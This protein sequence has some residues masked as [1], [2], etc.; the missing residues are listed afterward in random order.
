MFFFFFKFDPHIAI[1]GDIKNS[2]KIV[3]R[4]EVQTKLNH[5]LQEINQIY[6]GSIASN[7]TITLGDEFQGL[8]CSG[9]NTM[10][11]LQY[12]KKEMAPINIRFGIG[13]GHITTHVDPK[14]S[15]GADGPGYYM[16]RDSIETVKNYENRKE[17]ALCDMLI[18]IDGDNQLQEISLNST[19]KL[20]YS[21]E[22]R[23]TNKQKEI[24]NY[25][26]F[27]DMSQTEVSQHFNV[28]PSNIQQIL[29][30]SHY[31]AYKEAFDSINKILSEV[32]YDTKL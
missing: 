24:I 19:L 14:I 3:E 11:I 1:I 7:F 2:R 15:I 25:M 9:K 17:K 6:S 27:E 29:A 26:L 8:L 10:N 16:A 13:V 20:M 18:K 32:D 31:Y 22:Q 23:W 30:K 5:V 12:I 28:T 4:K 21:I